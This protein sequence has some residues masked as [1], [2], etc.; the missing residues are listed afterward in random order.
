M[1]ADGL[2]LADWLAAALADG[3]QRA[4]RFTPAGL[5]AAAGG[6]AGASV[7]VSF[8]EGWDLAWERGCRDRA[9]HGLLSVRRIWDE[10]LIG[11]LWL[12]DGAT[13]CAGC[14]EVRG[15]VA[16]DHPLL[17]R[18][19]QRYGGGP[20]PTGLADLVSVVVGNGVDHPLDPDG[21]IAVS[22]RSIRRHHVRRA[23]SCPICGETA[24]PATAASRETPVTRPETAVPH[25]ETAVP[26]PEPLRLAARPSPDRIPLRGHR[27]GIALD[28]TTLRARLVD[29]RFGPVLHVFRDTQA[30]FAMC[31]ALLPESRNMGYGRGLTVGQAEPV[32]IL[33]AY[34][35]LAGFPHHGRVVKGRSRRS[36]GEDAIDVTGLGHYTRAQLTHPS[37]RV[38]PW[39]ENAP[40]DWV[41][42]HDLAT[43]RPRL[44]PADVG[45]YLYEYEHRLD[46]H[47]SR[48][49]GAGTAP[50]NHFDESSSGCALGGS[51]EEAAVHSLLELAERD[52]FLMAWHC[53]RPLPRIDPATVSDP[54]SRQLLDLIA[55][56][57]FEAHLLVA[58]NDL[59]VP[60]VW[61][62]A[63]NRERPMPA[64]F[65]AAGSSV[66]PAA[67]V[68]A[69]L[70]ELGQI[71]AQPF[72]LDTERLRPMLTDPWKVET[73]ED[74]LELHALPE[75]L[76]L[77]ERFLTGP[78]TPLGEAFPGWPGQ[79]VAHAGGDVRGTLDHLLSCFRQAGLDEVVLVD[80]STRDHRDLGLRAAKAVVPGII[81]MCFGYAQQRVAGLPRL[82]R[83]M[84][85]AGVPLGEDELPPHPHPFP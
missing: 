4:A 51:L 74:H 60:V 1:T 37:S 52:A 2:E 16:V 82:S 26:R 27:D 29:P 34:E 75:S 7:D 50:R 83:A 6:T 49:A 85:A 3:G 36:L 24:R 66:E 59:G 44:V 18:P 45:F 71:V 38:L 62:C 48:R 15:L 58:S 81:P 72:A 19:E 84:A 11:P 25:P 35:R 77:L 61:G 17:G 53:G 54:V 67:A 30:P 73:L 31:D 14:A 56:K 39:S 40:T 23:F 32:A 65:S 57:G 46:Y 68:R 8:G 43:G 76:P 9:P 42:G 63:V 21:L 55:S 69:A 33:E 20:L 5:L 47:G 78:V 64:G 10:V 79:L 22:A 13:G 28:R 12:R 80:Q 41:W 70:W